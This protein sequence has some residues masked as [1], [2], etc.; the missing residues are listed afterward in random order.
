MDSSS[1]GKDIGPRLNGQKMAIDELDVAIFLH[2]LKVGDATSSQL[3][4]EIFRPEDEYT[5]NRLD[6][7]IRARLK[8][9][10]E[11]GMVLVTDAGDKK[12]YHVAKNRVF[13]ANDVTFRTL[14]G[15]SVSQRQRDFIVILT[16]SGGIWHDLADIFPTA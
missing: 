1:Q 3:A 5:R 11:R 15:H 6:N 9:Y 10:A 2:L 16:D 4:R 8:K 12:I 14:S 7:K 13:V